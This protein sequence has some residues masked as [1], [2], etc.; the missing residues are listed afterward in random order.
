MASNNR[1]IRVP[2][3]AMPKGE[4]PMPVVSKHVMDYLWEL[5]ESGRHEE[6]E[7]L[8][9]RGVTREVEAALARRDSGT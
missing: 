2:V 1:A 5:A 7:T 4:I 3:A 9:A 6:A 8:I